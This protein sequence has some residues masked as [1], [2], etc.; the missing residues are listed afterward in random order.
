MPLP[1]EIGVVATKHGGLMDK[2]ASWAIRW[3]THSPVNHAFLYVGGGQII[4]AVRHVQLSPWDSYPGTI[5]SGSM[6]LDPVLLSSIAADAR[7][8]LGESYNVLDILAIALAQS[9]L[10]HLV[11]GD[12]WWVKRLSDDHHLIC[13]QLVDQAYLDRGVHL[14]NDGRLPG[15][16]SPG[17]LLDYIREHQ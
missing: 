17:D 4:E 9:R 16:V 1:G 3:G 12:E 5:W 14:F 13:S 8:Y 7:G 15:L 6:G 11:D 10:G 2:F